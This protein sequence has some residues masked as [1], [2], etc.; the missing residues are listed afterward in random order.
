MDWPGAGLEADG[1][2]GRLCRN[3]GKRH[4]GMLL[5]MESGL[6]QEGIMN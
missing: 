6:I 2:G 3:P 5:G 4:C 1:P